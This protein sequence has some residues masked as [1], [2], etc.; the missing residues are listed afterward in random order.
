MILALEKCG[1]TEHR[2]DFEKMY[3]NALKR[4]QRLTKDNVCAYIGTK[5]KLF[6]LSYKT[7][8]GPTASQFMQE[9]MPR[10][11][12]MPDRVVR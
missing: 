12:V 4:Y 2:E 1:N 5:I 10:F 11:T 7:Q 3:I 9:K 6:N 8:F